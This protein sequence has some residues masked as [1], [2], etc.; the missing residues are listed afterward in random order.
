MSKFYRNLFRL[1]LLFLTGFILSLSI[2]VLAIRETAVVAQSNP[3]D[4][5]VGAAIAQYKEGKYNSA[6]ALWQQLLGQITSPKDQAVVRNNLALAYRQI[7]Q[8]AAAI[9][10]WEQAIQIYQRLDD[11]DGRRQVPKL[12]TEQAQAYHDQGQHQQAIALLQ[13]ALKLAGKNQ[14]S[15]TQAAALG[16][17]GNTHTAL[18]DYD[19][20]LESHQNSLQI[21]RQLNYPD[22]ITTSLNNLGNVYISRSERYRYQAN[23]AGLEAD[24]KENARLTE[25]AEQEIV[26]ARSA[27]EESVRE[28]QPIGGVALV[29]ALLNLNRM[30]E[31][32]RSPD[33][34]AINKNREQ[35]IALVE[36]LPDSRDKVYFSINLAESLR[37][38]GSNTQQ[39]LSKAIAVARNIG[40]KRAESFALGSLGLMY[41]QPG[42]EAKAME[43]IRQAQLAAQEVNA[44]DSLYRWQWQAG[45]LMKTAGNTKDAIASYEQA[46]ATLQ[47]IRSNLLAANQD[48][49]FDFR[50]SVE[51][52]YREL[53][54]ILLEADANTKNLSK[55]IDTLDLLKLAELQNFF[56]DECVQ[57]ARVDAKKGGS[58]LD[59]G[60]AIVYS[61]ILKDKTEMILR[62]PDGK[63]TN[64]AVS[65]PQ[66]Q[67]QQEINSLRQLLE[68]R[69]TN[70]YLIPA[71]KI[72]DA[73]MRPLEAELRKANPKTL[74]FIQDGVFRQ[75][76]M[77]ALH[78]GKQFLI[79]KY[80]IAT[81]P[82][83][84]LTTRTNPNSG[85]FNALIMG[86][87]V[88][89]PPFDA[90]TNVR[91]EA[92][93]V[94]EIMGG[95]ELLDNNFT[96]ATLQKNLQA[97]SYPIVH[98][99][100]HGKF[101]SDAASTFLL[102]FDTRITLD[103]MD[104]MLRS[105]SVSGG[106]LGTSREP[107]ELLTLSACQT[108]AGDNRATLGMAGVAVRAGARSALASLWYI[109]DE[110]TVPLIKEFYTQLRQPNV[111]KA[112]ALQK[113]QQKAIANLEYSHPA[114]WS[115]FILIG[116]WL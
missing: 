67:M 96:L 26:A 108:A 81:T 7:G 51:P 35:A 57:V 30:L 6:I 60:A 41:Q 24:D 64:Y 91:A 74:V 90:L 8:P 107:L 43:L 105:R 28:S 78:D 66:E 54:E 73:L 76:P 20:A 83:L 46:I 58:L 63:L 29:R 56:G 86:L 17:L 2:S 59:A 62:S 65:K 22:Y 55:V 52:V 95:K 92:A 104:N 48:L 68:K 19:K 100:T 112:E 9:A 33:W 15:R 72:Y 32:Q 109:N 3:Q 99:A 80:A 1:T 31:Q 69:S 106:N 93:S 84:S 89:R 113:A 39:L 98:L 12:M 5:L 103:Q 49:Q 4:G 34:D 50:D 42:Q 85:K 10:Q 18:G 61:V 16:A 13:S 40:D 21:A 111:S 88:E 45:R 53:M 114:V 101:G 47:S 14:D 82:S 36:T 44:A 87:T 116:N 11:D 102:A 25:F 115:P 27:F 110:A 23:V 77:A 94:R 79:E 71:Q 38:Q 37:S 70:E 75:V 97:K